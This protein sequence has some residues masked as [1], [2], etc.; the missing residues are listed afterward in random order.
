MPVNTLDSFLIK[1][2]KEFFFVEELLS[3]FIRILAEQTNSVDISKVFKNIHYIFSICF[4]LLSKSIEKTPNEMRI[5]HEVKKFLLNFENSIENNMDFEKTINKFKSID[6]QINEL[7]L[8]LKE[9]LKKEIITQKP[10]NLSKNR[11][12]A[13]I[14]SNSNS[15]SKLLILYLTSFKSFKLIHKQKILLLVLILGTMIYL[16]LQLMI[17]FSFQKTSI[18]PI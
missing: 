9:I 5:K 15:E 13:Q 12:E 6:T 18:L 4:D 8:K 17:G 3:S 11:Q 16:I 2:D 10:I 7:K 1:P 14:Q